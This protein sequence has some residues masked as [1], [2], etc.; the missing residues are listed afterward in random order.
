MHKLLLQLEPK[1]CMEWYVT[2][3][4]GDI[5]EL[6]K[7]AQDEPRLVNRKQA[8]LHQKVVLSVPDPR[9]DKRFEK[10]TICPIA[11]RYFQSRR[12]N[13]LSYL[14]PLIP[15]PRVGPKTMGTTVPT[16]V[17]PMGAGSFLSNVDLAEMLKGVRITKRNSSAMTTLWGKQSVSFHGRFCLVL[18]FDLEIF[19][20]PSVTDLGRSGIKLA[21]SRLAFDLYAI[22]CKRYTAVSADGVLTYPEIAGD[23]DNC[24][25]FCGGVPGGRRAPTLRCHFLSFYLMQPEKN[26]LFLAG[27]CKSYGTAA[28]SVRFNSLSCRRGIRLAEIVASLSRFWDT[29]N[30]SSQLS[31]RQYRNLM[32]DK[33]TARF[34]GGSPGPAYSD[35]DRDSCFIG[36]FAE[37]LCCRGQENGRRTGDSDNRAPAGQF[38]ILSLILQVEGILYKRGVPAEPGDTTTF[39]PTRPEGLSLMFG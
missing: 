34:I 16:L 28:I 32:K 27:P 39:L 22:S 10:Q 25:I 9:L 11:L 33:I 38:R 18:S 4:K 23:D 13:R 21:K 3:S 30:S 5:Q 24:R 36:S 15:S 20:A 12:I 14:R 29:G 2:A 26:T 8:P 17:Y 19:V 6:L 31:P 37:R 7:L 35:A 1:K